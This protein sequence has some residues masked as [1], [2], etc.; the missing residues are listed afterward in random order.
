MTS[1]LTAL[2]SQYS[3]L[4]KTSNHL[5]LFS[6]G[7]ILSTC[8]LLVLNFRQKP[9]VISALLLSSLLSICC[10]LDNRSVLPLVSARLNQLNSA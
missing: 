9:N 2:H 7:C 3:T 1:R 10:A 6:S 5:L 8:L 4:I